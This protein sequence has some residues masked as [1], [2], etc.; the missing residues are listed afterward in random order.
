MKHNYFS[1]LATLF[2]VV[3]MNM[4][5]FAQNTIN[6]NESSSQ[7]Q[8]SRST[9][10]PSLAERGLKGVSQQRYFQYNKQLLSLTQKNKG[11]IL[12]LDFFEGKQYKAV[13]KN[14]RKNETGLISI[15]GKIENT[16]F[17]YCYIVISDKG[18][19][20]SVELPETDEVF[21]ASTKEGKSYLYQ[22]SLSAMK[23]DELP[24]AEPLIPDDLMQSLPSSHNKSSNSVPSSSFRVADDI[25]E[26]VTIDLLIAY[27]E[28]AKV[29]TATSYLSYATD[30]DQLI[31]MALDKANVT[32]NNSETGITFRVVYRYETDYSEVDASTDLNRITGTADGYIDDIHGLR[33]QY[34]ADIVILLTEMTGLGGLAWTLR[35]PSGSPDYAFTVCR[36]QQTANT[37]TMVHEI[38]HLMGCGHHKLQGGSS[39]LYSYSHGWGGYTTLGTRY[40]TVMTYINGSH[41]PETGNYP[42]IPHF[43]DPNKMFEGVP[44]G[45]G[46]DGNNV[47]TL[48]TSKHVISRYREKQ[49]DYNADLSNII[50]SAGQLNPA[51]DPSTLNYTVKVPYTTEQVSISGLPYNP[52]SIVTEEVT[53]YSLGEGDN[54]FQLVVTSPNNVQQTYTITV[55]RMSLNSFSETVWVKQNSGV[56]SNLND[57]QMIDNTIGYVCGDNGVIL[58]TTD[59]GNNWIKQTTNTVTN[60]NCILFLDENIGYT[61]GENQLILKTTDGGN[62]WNFAYGSGNVYG[63]NIYGMYAE[64]ASKIWVLCENRIYLYDGKNSVV[65]PS[66]YWHTCYD[67]C[68]LNEN[69]Y[70]FGAHSLGIIYAS[71]PNEYYFPTIVAVPDD[72]ARH[73]GIATW[74]GT[75]T[76]IACASGGILQKADFNSA[77][78]TQVALTSSTTNDLKDITFT[79]PQTAYVVGDVGTVIKSIDQGDSWMDISPILV[80]LQNLEAVSFPSENKG[81]IVG[82]NGTILYTESAELLISPLSH[83]VEANAGSTKTFSVNSNLSWTTSCLSPWLSVTTETSAIIVTTTEAN[84]AAISRSATITVSANG[85]DDV[86]LTVVQEGTEP[87]SVKMKEKDDIIIYPNPVANELYLQFGNSYDD[88]EITFY[89]MYGAAVFKGKTSLNTTTLNISHLNAGIYYIQIQD[90]EKNENIYRGKL[91]KK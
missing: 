32:M 31:E 26:D 50:L 1:L 58:K 21:I 60:L 41:F 36:V 63:E 10:L 62:T 51:F 35:S 77:T 70:V 29:F 90:L 24:G 88:V 49:L 78:P 42:N 89:N 53:N 2:F 81:W 57:I 54:I 19:T 82:A 79:S 16:E 4:L 65:L 30:I 74:P 6:I 61:G 72:F 80:T 69:T 15:T 68:I 27:T 86:I 64:S 39:G 76:V 14:V 52:F 20:I 91:I 75:N 13:I 38:G 83:S 40:S 28:K 25:E 84:P 66:T 59:G 37:F 47:L 56:T 85:V 7:S 11:D 5:M 43:S 34:N 17:G 33:D 22:S 18:I 12:L 87:T 44:I 71:S 8:I 45:D 3:F 48:K 46:A 55:T 67:M 9:N 73:Y 23:E